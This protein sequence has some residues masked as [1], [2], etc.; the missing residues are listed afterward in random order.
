MINCVCLIISNCIL[1]KTVRQHMTLSVKHQELGSFA[2][3]YVCVHTFLHFL[4]PEGKGWSVANRP[5]QPHCQVLDYFHWQPYLNAPIF[6]CS[7]QTTH[8]KYEAIHWRSP[9]LIELPDDFRW[10]MLIGWWFGCH[11]LF[12]HI[13]GC[14]SSQLTF[15]FFRG[16]AHQPVLIG[17]FIYPAATG[18]HSGM[19]DLIIDID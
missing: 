12:S 18:C 14:S 4:P 7:L 10:D 3:G 17:W 2:G 19:A 6:G 11:F 8:G 16:V 1:D 13:L 5:R 15:L 9:S